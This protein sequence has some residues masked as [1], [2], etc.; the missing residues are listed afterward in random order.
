MN[1]TI[2]AR[3]NIHLTNLIEFNIENKFF[4]CSHGY[5][6]YMAA[7]NS[8]GE[9]ENPSKTTICPGFHLNP[10]SKNFFSCRLEQNL[11]CT[12]KIETWTELFISVYKT[13]V[14]N[15]CD[16]RFIRPTYHAVFITVQCADGIYFIYIKKINM[17]SDL[18]R[19][20]HNVHQL[21][22]QTSFIY[23]LTMTMF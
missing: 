22:R 12:P 14:S 3:I 10:S 6:V 9:P 8:N 5:T 18:W 11:C 17:K 13:S 2:L 1:S 15:K 20:M 21:R 19:Y 16:L 7:S 4:N 23:Q